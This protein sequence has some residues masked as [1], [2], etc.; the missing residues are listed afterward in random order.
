MD[1]IRYLPLFRWNSSS[2]RVPDESSEPSNPL[3]WATSIIVNIF[4]FVS[5]LCWSVFTWISRL[6]IDTDITNSFA[7]GIDN[8]AGR[9]FGIITESNI[10]YIILPLILLILIFAYMKSPKGVGVR[11]ILKLTIIPLCSLILISSMAIAV[12]SQSTA[13]DDWERDYGDIYR[14]CERWIDR[15][16]T[17]DVNTEVDAC[18]EPEVPYEDGNDDKNEDGND[19]KRHKLLQQYPPPPKTNPLTP[20]WILRN[21]TLIFDTIADVP[22]RALNEISVFENRGE[23]PLDCP[24]YINTLNRTG[25][26][27]SIDEGGVTNT[28]FALAKTFSDIWLVSQYNS[29]AIERYGVNNGF[30]DLVYCRQLEGAA[31]IS[32][33]EQHRLTLASASSSKCVI[34]TNKEKSNSNEEY[35]DDGSNNDCGRLSE[36][37]NN[38]HLYLGLEAAKK[39]LGEGVSGGDAENL[40]VRQDPFVSGLAAL[41]FAIED[42]RDE[43][44]DG[45]AC[46]RVFVFTASMNSWI[47]G[48]GGNVDGHPSGTGNGF[49]NVILASEFDDQG[50]P[51]GNIDNHVLRTIATTL[52]YCGLGNDN[53]KEPP[54]GSLTSKKLT[55]NDENKEK[56]SNLFWSQT[57]YKCILTMGM[58]I[59]GVDGVPPEASGI[60]RE[61]TSKL[62]FLG[63]STYMDIEKKI[64]NEGI[65]DLAQVNHITTI[66]ELL[67][68]C[69]PHTRDEDKPDGTANNIF[70]DI[71]QFAKCYNG[72]DFLNPPNIPTAYEPFGNSDV[73][74]YTQLPIVIVFE[75]VIYTVCTK[76]EEDVCNNSNINVYLKNLND[77]ITIFNN[78]L[79]YN[80][81]YV[82]N[83]ESEKCIENRESCNEVAGGKEECRNY[84][85]ELLDDITAPTPTNSEWSWDNNGSK[86]LGIADVLAI[87]IDKQLEEIHDRSDEV[88][89]NGEHSSFFTEDKFTQYCN[90]YYDVWEQDDIRNACKSNSINDKDLSNM[91]QKEQRLLF[92]YDETKNDIDDESEYTIN[93]IQGSQDYCNITEDK[94]DNSEYCLLLIPRVYFSLKLAGLLPEES[95]LEDLIEGSGFIVDG[96]LGDSSDDRSLSELEEG[97]FDCYD[98]TDITEAALCPGASSRAYQSVTF[99]GIVSELNLSQITSSRGSVPFGLLAPT[100]NPLKGEQYKHK[101]TFTESIRKDNFWLL[102]VPKNP[103]EMGYELKKLAYTHRTNFGDVQ[104][105]KEKELGEDGDYETAPSNKVWGLRKGFGDIKVTEVRQIDSNDYYKVSSDGRFL[106][107]LIGGE[108][109]GSPCALAWSNQATLGKSVD[110]YR[111]NSFCNFLDSFPGFIDYITGPIV[112]ACNR[113]FNFIASFGVGNSR[114]LTESDFTNVP[115]IGGGLFEITTKG[116]NIDSLEA[117]SDGFEDEPQ[118]RA[119]NWI[120][121]VNDTRGL[122]ITTGAS[123]FM[124]MIVSFILVL[125]L[126][127]F[128]MAGFVSQIILAVMLVMFPVVLLILIIPSRKAVDIAKRYFANIISLYFVKLMIVFIFSLLVITIVATNALLLE[129]TSSLPNLFKI[130]VLGMS[131]L[132]GIFVLNR[133]FRV[134]TGSNKKLLSFNT[135]KNITTNKIKSGKFGL[136]EYTAD[137]GKSKTLQ[138]IKSSKT[139]KRAI[140]EAQRYLPNKRHQAIT[141]F[142]E[143]DY[144]ER[145][146]KREGKISNYESEIDRLSKKVDIL[147]LKPASTENTS[148]IK[149]ANIE[150]SN[151][152]KAIK[153]VPI[154]RRDTYLKAFTKERETFKEE[155]RQ[156]FHRWSGSGVKPG[157]SFVGNL[158]GKFYKKAKDSKESFYKNTKDNRKKSYEKYKE[159][160]EKSK[161]KHGKPPS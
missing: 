111:S 125:I 140:K 137:R 116:S 81:K 101:G 104:W 132:L 43:G 149:K 94:K 103:E 34:L 5:R 100:G 13:L 129:L 21:I 141:E 128:M 51:R 85:L 77:C 151:L 153:K 41:E 126:G 133:I 154:V 114:N 26:A 110:I 159:K 42:C 32:V 78:R 36:D 6:F 138:K 145:K 18:P 112:E 50:G 61:T 135:I 127:L 53:T 105:E 118:S 38:S 17:G 134:V 117:N 29:S 44:D 95:I 87:E 3:H 58:A 107:S 23:S 25:K 40:N 148:A 8:Y 33:K 62:T 96:N 30:A 124:N 122:S 19:D 97:D 93:K 60:G 72:N 90:E 2:G 121:T 75:C 147:K 35:N 79:P 57:A 115:E 70:D 37:T 39:I 76:E 55:N 20:S 68:E 150:I 99:S 59:L 82:C 157:E 161:K 73:D 80:M 123:A 52:S 119:I 69:L 10:L 28:R 113:L 49:D 64:F 130:F 120:K 54:K 74:I 84:F 24:N 155:R 31:N 102:C 12:S 108:H 146:S 63:N 83:I 86:K 156:D 46:E 16:P 89:R 22:L 56:V 109:W 14:I 144:S 4:E 27:V 65:I 67:E 160:R 131:P 11:N 48:R 15:I 45:L 92:G 139:G 98:D 91:L 71:E 9:I 7:N 136:A 106:S 1:A 142:R 47:V 88:N 66:G 152:K 143:K 158:T